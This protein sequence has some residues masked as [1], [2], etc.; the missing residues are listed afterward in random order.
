MIDDGGGD[1]DVDGPRSVHVSSGS[2]KGQMVPMSAAVLLLSSQHCQVLPLTTAD[3]DA[4]HGR[5]G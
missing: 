3:D 4:D 1:D 5:Y 2:E